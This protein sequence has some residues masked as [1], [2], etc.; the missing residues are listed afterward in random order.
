MEHEA[1]F[2][3]LRIA[4]KLPEQQTS[5]IYFAPIP[6]EQKPATTVDFVTNAAVAQPKRTIC[7]N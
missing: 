6:V 2:Q 5:S 7:Y 3:L 4:S 1:V